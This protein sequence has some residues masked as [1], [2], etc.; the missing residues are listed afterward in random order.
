MQAQPAFPQGLAPPAIPPRARSRPVPTRKN[1]SN[2]LA[3]EKTGDCVERRTSETGE[4]RGR[5]DRVGSAASEIDGI[6]SIGIAMEDTAIRETSSSSSFLQPKHHDPSQNPPE[7]LSMNDTPRPPTDG[8]DPSSFEDPDTSNTLTPQPQQ[9]PSFPGF[10]DRK[11]SYDTDTSSHPEDERYSLG[12]RTEGSPRRT[13]RRVRTPIIPE[14]TTSRPSLDHN[15][16]D[17]D[18][19]DPLNAPPVPPPTTGE[20]SRRPS[21]NLTNLPGGS[22]SSSTTSSSFPSPITTPQESPPFA[23]HPPNPNHPLVQISSSS[24]SSIFKRPRGSL[25]AGGGGSS[26][27]VHSQSSNQPG[28]S[29]KTSAPPS[30]TPSQPPVNP[31][32]YVNARKAREEERRL[33]LEQKRETEKNAGIV[34]K[35]GYKIVD[36]VE[37]KRSTSGVYTRT[38][39]SRISPILGDHLQDERADSK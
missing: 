7:F 39:G 26:W 38:S 18:P 21:S 9:V 25:S 13:A 3:L 11:G 8:F 2:S 27:S 12:R 1:S 19:H 6:G 33:E 28:G 16:S 23:F 10:D 35:D 32:G 29:R 15:P 14:R 24:S 30:S 5:I 4:Q 22:H 20:G 31:S 37:K 36:G 17:Q 34:V